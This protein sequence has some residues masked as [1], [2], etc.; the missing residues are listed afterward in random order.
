MSGNLSTRPSD[1][2]VD[3][4]QVAISAAT[5]GP[6]LWIRGRVCSGRLPD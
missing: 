3:A 4:D 2:I 5:E 6:H 1:T